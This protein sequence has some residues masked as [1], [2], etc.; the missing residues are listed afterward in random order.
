MGT[1]GCKIHFAEIGR[2]GKEEERAIQRYRKVV[3]LNVSLQSEN[4]WTV[5]DALEAMAVKETV[6]MSEVKHYY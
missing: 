3:N 6:R 5:K 2:G 4:I 1:R